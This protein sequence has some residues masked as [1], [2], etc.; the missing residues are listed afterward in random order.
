ML[1]AKSELPLLLLDTVSHG[2]LAW[3]AGY[4]GWIFCPTREGNTQTDAPLAVLGVDCGRN[5]GC[6][7][8]VGMSVVSVLF[9]PNKIRDGQVKTSRRFRAASV[10]APREKKMISR[11]KVRV[12]WRFQV[13]QLFNEKAVDESNRKKQQKAPSV[14]QRYG[15]KINFAI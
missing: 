12:R 7:I 13:L 15:K 14:A 5:N 9:T 2:T 6:E 1:F 4:L 3:R 8:D 10:P 11:F